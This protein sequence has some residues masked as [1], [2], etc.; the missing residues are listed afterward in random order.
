MRPGVVFYTDNLLRPEI[1][2]LCSRQLIAASG[3]MEIITVGLNQSAGFGTQ[4][5]MFGQRGVIQMHRQILVGLETSKADYVFLAEHDVLYHPSHFEFSPPRGDS[6]YYN[7]NVWRCRWPD[8]HAVWADDTQQV[9]GLC[10]ARPLLI[11]FYQQRLAQLAVEGFNR[12]YE[13]GLK[14]TVGGQRV[15]NWTALVPNLDIRHDAN[16][17]LSKWAPEQFRNRKYARGWKEADEV[18]GWGKT[19]DV[20]KVKA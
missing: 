19:A 17:T 10:A 1:A 11:S 9:S 3:G 2:N 6:F 13:P 8:G 15:E 20:F 4:V 18:M 12:H 7:V 5:T 16:L 14:Q